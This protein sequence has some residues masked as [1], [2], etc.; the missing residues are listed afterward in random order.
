MC[1][2]QTMTPYVIL[3][4]LLFTSISFA[5]LLTLWVTS[6]FISLFILLL[7]FPFP[8]M[9]THN[10]IRTIHLVVGCRS[11]F[12]T[13]VIY[14]FY[15]LVIFGPSRQWALMLGR[16]WTSSHVSLLHEHFKFSNKHEK[17][18]ISLTIIFIYWH[19]GW[20]FCYQRI[21]FFFFFIHVRYSHFKLVTFEISN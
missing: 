4:F 13:E 18:L 6:L 10:G 14:F 17:L 20:W 7:I 3:L 2:L 11:T 15:W 5:L 19:R 9:L 12:I 1:V 8:L 16:R 21:Y